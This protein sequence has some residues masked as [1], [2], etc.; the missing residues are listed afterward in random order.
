MRVVRPR[1]NQVPLLT[2]FYP[3]SP[4]VLLSQIIPKKNRR[5]ICKYLFQEG[6]L[7]AKKDYNLAKHPE[8]DVPNLQVIKR[9]QIF[10]SREYVRETFAWQH[11]Y[12]YLADDDR[13]PA[14]LAL[15]LPVTAP[16]GD[17]HDSK[18]IGQDLG[19]G[20]DVGVVLVLEVLR[21]ILVTRAAHLRSFSH[22]SG[23]AST[24]ISYLYSKLF[25]YHQ[26]L[27]RVL[28]G[29]SRMPF[30]VVFLVENDEKFFLAVTL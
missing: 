24:H 28:R 15:A 4:P 8:M 29:Q 18:E 19:I 17:H 26:N 21:V 27:L 2:Q 5:E 10:K 7:Y 3:R 12:W 16:A 14:R 30:L 6:L 25:S 9:M 20:M 22:L 1:P 11:Y 23:Y 13:R